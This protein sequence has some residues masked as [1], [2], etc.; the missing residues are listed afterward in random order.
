ME[1]MGIVMRI[2]QSPSIQLGVLKYSALVD[3]EIQNVAWLGI[4]RSWFNGPGSNQQFVR[5]AEG[6]EVG[7]IPQIA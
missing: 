7:L 6:L 5:I 4:Q 1:P 2:F 3:K